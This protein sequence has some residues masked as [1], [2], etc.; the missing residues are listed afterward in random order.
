MR[1][2]L[3]CFVLLLAFGV[4]ARA[5]FEGICN[6]GEFE[7]GRK[8]STRTASANPGSSS[9]ISINPSAVPTEKG[10]G[11]EVIGFKGAFDAGLVR[12]LGRVGAAISPSNSEDT[13]FGAPAYEYDADYLTRKT[14]REKYR[15]QKVTLA[16]AVNLFEYK[17]SALRRMSLN[18][19][20]LGK[21]NQT[22]YA[23][24][25]GA[26]LNGILG[27]FTFGYS[28]YRDETQLATAV[29]DDGGLIRDKV[30]SIVENYSVG[31]YLN[32]LVLDYS[33][34]RLQNSDVDRVD[35]FTV[36]L[37]LDRWVLSFSERR[38]T[39]RRPSFN[40][41][42]EKLDAEATKHEHFY[43]AQFKITGNF[44]VGLMY[45][46]YLLR[47]LSGSLTLMF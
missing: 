17:R 21:Y 12:G 40:Y 33:T 38:E 2:S 23:T 34:L 16:T 1:A 36:S 45:N 6:L 7:C 27:P 43:G 15:Q 31:L 35:L 10:L 14:G 24:T 29:D 26:G 47:E 32:S 39:S 11:F 9:R 46:Y 22:T 41:H 4:P 30:Q 44:M 19:G 20:V 28:V 5:V 8:R 25:P 3:L 37:L 13:F 18:L 42:F